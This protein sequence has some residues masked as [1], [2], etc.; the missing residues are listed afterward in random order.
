MTQVHFQEFATLAVL[1]V[2]N[3]ANQTSVVFL[4]THVLL[5]LQSFIVVLLS[6]CFETGF[7][8]R[9]VLGRWKR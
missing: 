7:Y 5:N 9:K 6:S 1:C 3:K 8:E 4:L 2:I